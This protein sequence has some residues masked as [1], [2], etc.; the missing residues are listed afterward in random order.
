MDDLVASLVLSS[1]VPSRSPLRDLVF[2]DTQDGPLAVCCDDDGSVWTWDPARDV[3]Q[4]RPLEFAFADDPVFADHP[5]AT[6]LIDRVAVV[7][8]N[9]RL[10]LMAGADEQ[11]WAVWDLDS[12]ATLRRAPHHGDYVASVVAL[13]AGGGDQPRFAVTT[14]YSD[15][16]LVMDAFGTQEP[17]EWEHGGASMH[18]VGFLLAG[19]STLAWT[20]STDCLA[21]GEVGSDEEPL[22]V[23]V[24]GDVSA[25]AV[26]P[27]ARP[28]MLAGTERGE[29][30]V[31]E[32]RGSL[33]PDDDGEVVRR[34]HGPLPG[35]RGELRALAALPVGGRRVAVSG[36]RDGAVRMWDLESGTAI[37]EPLTGHDSGVDAI[38]TT[39]FDDRPVAASAGRDGT[40]H[41]WS[42]PA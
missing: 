37:G 3:W 28:L 11:S 10:L 12:G 1:L 2:V 21:I 31:W 26:L 35:H 9:G 7:A 25:I 29:L 8:S 5:D 20:D 15:E 19:R 33:D 17:Q 27:D 16:L 4:R 39:V 40:I 22:N 38:A 24:D 18:L 30:H 42:I 13:P 6:N 34:L 32:L 23:D 14:Q 41:L 36:G